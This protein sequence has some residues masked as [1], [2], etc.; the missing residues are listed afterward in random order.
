M[1]T[2]VLSNAVSPQHATARVSLLLFG[3]AVSLSPLR[4]FVH[5]NHVG[6]P[7][8]I[9]IY[10]PMFRAALQAITTISSYLHT[11]PALQ[12]KL[13]TRSYQDDRLIPLRY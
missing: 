12:P 11:N 10:P 2:D 6:M 13:R 9:F 4:V 1:V 3:P 8:T 7:H 5:G